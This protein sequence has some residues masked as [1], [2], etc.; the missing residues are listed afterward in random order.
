[1][2]IAGFLTFEFSG[3]SGEVGGAFFRSTFSRGA[4][5][6]CIFG[7]RNPGKESLD[8]HEKRLSRSRGISAVTGRNKFPLEKVVMSPHATKYRLF[9][10]LSGLSSGPTV[11]NLGRYYQSKIMWSLHSQLLSQRLSREPSTKWTENERTII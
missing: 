1:M 3:S 5:E 2:R 10:S 11:P 6:E 4:G 8:W 7:R 9:V